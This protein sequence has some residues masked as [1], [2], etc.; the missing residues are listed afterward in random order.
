MLGIP[1]IWREM[2]DAARSKATPRMRLLAGLAGTVLIG[3]L[4]TRRNWEGQGHYLM[5]CLHAAAVALILFAGPFLTADS[6]SSER[7]GGTL[8]L[9]F[10]TPVRGVEIVLAKFAVQWLRLLSLWLVAVPLGVVPF[11]M[12]AVDG[13]QLLGCLLLQAGLMIVCLAA[14]MLASS[15]SFKATMAMTAAQTISVLLVAANMAVVSWAGAG[16]GLTVT[17]FSGSDLPKWLEAILGGALLLLAPV[18]WESAFSAA[19]GALLGNWVLAAGM[20]VIVAALAAWALLVRIGRRLGRRAE[21]N[22]AAQR[23]RAWLREKFLTPLI[24]KDSLRRRLNAK[25]RANPLVWLEYRTPWSRSAVWVLLGVVI[26]VESMMLVTSPYSYSYVRGQYY[27]ALLLA[28]VLAVMSASSFQRERENG[29]F[30]LLLVAPFTEKTLLHGRLNAVWGHYAPVVVL[31][32]IFF[33]ITV[34]GSERLYGQGMPSDYKQG[35]LGA[36]LCGI[37]VPLAGLYFALRMKSFLTVLFWT[38]LCGIIAPTFAWSVVMGIAFLLTKVALGT[39]HLAASGLGFSSDWGQW[40]GFLE[41]LYLMKEIFGLPAILAIA[42]PHVLLSRFF[43]TKSLR[44]LRER[45][46]AE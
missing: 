11:L 42:A 13:R 20:N 10:L 5:A 12:G 14:G 43:Y 45:S 35:L 27:L 28:V 6:I 1:I 26:L 37:T 23:R 29:A 7:R 39:L 2:R 30:E 40:T 34:A 31:F 41:N 33:L 24:F 32:A 15:F 46:F 19:A 18:A 21:D 9:L 44:I 17:I 36:A 16:L 22:P 3:W 25:M 38:I 4:L 8:D